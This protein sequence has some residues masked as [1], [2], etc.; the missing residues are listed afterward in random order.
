MWAEKNIRFLCVLSLYSYFLFQIVFYFLMG[1]GIF[2]A[3]GV[4]FCSAAAVG[5][6]CSRYKF[7][8]F[9]LELYSISFLLCLCIEFFLY[10]NLKIIKKPVMYKTFLGLSP[11]NLFVFIL[12]YLKLNFKK[13][14]P[15]EVSF[16]LLVPLCFFVIWRFREALRSDNWVQPSPPQSTE[17][18]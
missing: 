13:Y 9:L 10:K 16:L 15:E 4:K 11:L 1:V 6:V 8:E 2:N 5:S 3:I 17:S 12:L 7:S 18:A 14:S